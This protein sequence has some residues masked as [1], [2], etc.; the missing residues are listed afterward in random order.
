[1]VLGMERNM[2]RKNGAERA[3]KEGIKEWTGI[4]TRGR[5]NTAGKTPIIRRNGVIIKNITTSG[6]LNHFTQ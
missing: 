2:E 3:K 4:K 5:K 1:M 6:G